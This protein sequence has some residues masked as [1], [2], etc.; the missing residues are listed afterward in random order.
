MGEA[1]ARICEIDA[2]EAVAGNISIYTAWQIEVRRRFSIN[3]VITLPM[4]APTST[5]SSAPAARR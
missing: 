2:S 5:S 1:G 4:R 3:E